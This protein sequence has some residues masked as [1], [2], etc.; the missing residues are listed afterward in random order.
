MPRTWLDGLSP[1]EEPDPPIDTEDVVDDLIEQVLVDRRGGDLR[2]PGQPRRLRS[3]RATAALVGAARPSKCRRN[4]SRR[5]LGREVERAGLL[6]QVRRSGHDLDLVLAP[7]LRGGLPVEPEDDVVVAADDQQRRRSDRAEARSGQVGSTAAG[8]DRGDVGVGLGGGPQRRRRTGARPE[9]ADREVGERRP[10]RGP[11]GSPRPGGSA[12]RS[13]SNTFARSSSSAGVSRSK[14][15]V[16]MPASLS[17]A[18]R[19]SGCGGCGGCSRCRGRRSPG[20]AGPPAPRRG[21][22][23]ATAPAGIST[24]AL[25]TGGSAGSGS[26]A[27]GPGGR[28]TGP[29][30]EVEHGVVGD[31]GEVVV[32]L[33]HGHEARRGARG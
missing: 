23:R 16:P 31:L 10:G 26:A 14:R 9:V 19:R 6:E 21:R 3:D 11:S 5:G 27:A 4:Q 33:A 8:D 28:A 24:S 12:R 15:S 29:A 22:S 25:R 2:R 18:R 30:Q 17:D 7:Q 32:E 1:G 13:T 20:P